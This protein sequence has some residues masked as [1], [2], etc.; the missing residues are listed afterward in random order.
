M[1]LKT[2]RVFFVLSLVIC[3]FSCA[4]K[5]EAQAKQKALKHIV[6]FQF[7]DEIPA[8]R[9]TQAIKDFLA[10]EDDIPEIIS[11]EGGEDISV[12]GLNQGFTHCF[13][14]TFANEAA[15]DIYIPHPAHK[16]LA[17]KNKPLMQDLVVVDVWGER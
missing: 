1:T 2:I 6:C 7:K 16:K 15:R 11:F 10:L 9:R 4:S 17:E 14:L 3:T 8:E 5:T 12:E 13:I